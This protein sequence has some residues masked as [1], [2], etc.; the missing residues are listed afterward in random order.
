MASAER[1]FRRKR[2]VRGEA[3]VVSQ[4]PLVLDNRVRRRC[5]LLRAL[6]GPDLLGISGLRLRRGGF[7]TTRLGIHLLFELRLLR[8][9][10]LV[11]HFLSEVADLLVVA[12]G[13]HN[14][15]LFA[16]GLG[17]RL[18]MVLREHDGQKDHDRYTGNDIGLRLLGKRAF[19][20]DCPVSQPGL[21]ID[22]LWNLLLDS[23]S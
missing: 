19:R 23:R 8:R 2:K 9:T 11:G 13:N 20:P 7:E 1:W 14:S 12:F 22:L 21:A 4:F 10:L 18:G 15:R 17:C 5:C 6:H 16:L 3:R